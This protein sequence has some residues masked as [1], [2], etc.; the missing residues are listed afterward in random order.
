MHDGA[1]IRA[2][3]L[4]I[5]RPWLTSVSQLLRYSA[6]SVHNNESVDTRAITQTNTAEYR[7]NIDIANQGPAANISLAHCQE[8]VLEPDLISFARFATLF[9]H[10]IYKNCDR[11]SGRKFSVVEVAKRREWNRQLITHSLA[12]PKICLIPRAELDE[13]WQ[14]ARVLCEGYKPIRANKYV[15]NFVG[16]KRDSYRALIKVMPPPIP[17][18]AAESLNFAPRWRKEQ[19]RKN[20]LHTSRIANREKRGER[21]RG[22]GGVECRGQ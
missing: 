8:N 6:W 5:H 17:Y 12:R 4:N 1:T 15:S 3:T 21:K 20:I 13:M 2:R 10:S 18:S 19:V 9:H 11:I 16:V 7:H 22:R 14:I